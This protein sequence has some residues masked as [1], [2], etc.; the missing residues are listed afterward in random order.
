MK[1]ATAEKETGLDLRAFEFPKLT[2]L[3]IAFATLGADPKLLA[4]AKR[5]GFYNKDTPYNRLF[6]A[7]FFKGG[8][9]DFKA[10]V[11]AEF[12][13]RA[14]PYLRALMGSFEPAHEDKEAICA[15]L[16]SELVNA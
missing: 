11:P 14:T 15:L 4:E 6:S 2:G 16:L 8:K 1:A 10:D 12:K 13:E 3:D 7:L 9:L 5:R